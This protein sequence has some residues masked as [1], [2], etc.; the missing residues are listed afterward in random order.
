LKSKVPLDIIISFAER[1]YVN[2]KD[3]LVD[4]HRT[5]AAW[6]LK[7]LAERSN[8]NGGSI[9]LELEKIIR[10]FVP[11]RRYDQELYYQDTLAQFLRS[12]FHDTE[13][14]VSRGSTRPD[15]VVK[16]I[17]IE[18]KGPTSNRD[19][20]TIANKCLRYRRY[21]PSGLICVLFSVNVTP[22]Y[23]EDWLKAMQETHPDVRVIKIPL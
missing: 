17:A 14:E 2:I 19:L 21:F 12:K 20:D 6:E 5:E 22:Q 9:L 3:I 18:V 10:E 4:I 8:K 13:I 7:A 23:Y 16:G 1:N 15:I 11:L